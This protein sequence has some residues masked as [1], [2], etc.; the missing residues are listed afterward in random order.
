MIRVLY[1]ANDAEGKEVVDALESNRI[2][3]SVYYC[4]DA[5]RRAYR[6]PR[7]LTGQGEWIGREAI[8]KYIRQEPFLATL[9]ARQE[10]S[11]RRSL[12]I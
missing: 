1:V 8:L 10:D 4:P 6:C 2:E 9:R 12:G 5:D 3:C 11:S 7:L